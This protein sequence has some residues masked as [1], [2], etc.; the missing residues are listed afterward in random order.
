MWVRGSTPVVLRS[1]PV[2]GVGCAPLRQSE[3]DDRKGFTVERA[4]RRNQSDDEMRR[5]ELRSIGGLTPHL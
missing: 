3:G 4:D 1:D 5:G 2:C